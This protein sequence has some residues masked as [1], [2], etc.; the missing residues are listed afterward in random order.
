MWEKSFACL[1][2]LTL[3]LF[4]LNISV[5]G[6]LECWS[7]RTWMS[8]ARWISWR[9]SDAVRTT[10]TVTSARLLPWSIVW[11][12]TRAHVPPAPLTSAMN[13]M[14]W[15]GLLA[16]RLVL[17][18]PDTHSLPFPPTPHFFNH[19]DMSLTGIY[20]LTL[21][22]CPLSVTSSKEGPEQ[23]LIIVLS[24]VKELFRRAKKPR[25]FFTPLPK[26]FN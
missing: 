1:G 21:L 22:H 3:Q 18:R 8:D 17:S 16:P 10:G 4:F 23:N 14:L 12:A 7:W 24:R 20:C 25:V 15:Q 13:T 2:I 6:E 5:W 11:P 26:C 19:V 9:W